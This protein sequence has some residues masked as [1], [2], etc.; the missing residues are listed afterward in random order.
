[1]LFLPLQVLNWLSA[2]TLASRSSATR[3]TTRDTLLAAPC[4]LAATPGTACGAAGRWSAWRGSGGLGISPCQP[5]SVRQL[6]LL[7]HPLTNTFLVGI[8]LNAFS[9]PFA[10]TYGFNF[11]V[12]YICISNGRGKDTVWGVFRLSA[13]S[14]AELVGAVLT[15]NPLL[16]AQGWRGF[17]RHCKETTAFPVPVLSLECVKQSGTFW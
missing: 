16:C 14:S 9:S 13:L 4:P 11:Y 2:R 6:S 1:M 15:R 7:K 3:S 10:N 17:L 5:V 8:T 12:E